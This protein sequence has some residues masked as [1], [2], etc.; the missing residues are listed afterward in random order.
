MHVDGR[1]QYVPVVQDT[2]NLLRHANQAQS[3]VTYNICPLT[4][5][6]YYSPH[7]LFLFYIRCAYFADYTYLLHAR[8]TLALHLRYP[9]YLL[10]PHHISGRIFNVRR[11]VRSLQ[12]QR[13]RPHRSRPRPRHVRPRASL[14]E[15]SPHL[16]SSHLIS[17]HL[18][19]SRLISPHLMRW[20]ASSRDLAPSREI[21]R[22]LAR[23]PMLSDDSHLASS[24]IMPWRV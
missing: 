10:Y 8:T 21:S 22:R 2:L 4:H 3:Q 15:I 6:T 23:I 14:G 19:S 1:H 24:L 17:P 13:H 5:S 11:R 16:A 9:Q 20:D 12:L 7:L 18:A